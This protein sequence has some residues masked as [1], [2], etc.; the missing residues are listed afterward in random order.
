[1]P[2]TNGVVPE[3][4]LNCPFPQTHVIS[5]LHSPVFPGHR[6]SPYA[7]REQDKFIC[8]VKRTQIPAVGPNYGHATFPALLR[9]EKRQCLCVSVWFMMTYDF[10]RAHGR[11]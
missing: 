3:M 8:P 1:M 4:P 5:P 2:A 7:T 6:I 10:D 11:Y 9:T